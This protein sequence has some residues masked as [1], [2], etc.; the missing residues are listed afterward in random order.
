M[1]IK[2]FTT[3]MEDEMYNK[4]EHIA[5]FEGRSVNS[6]LL[7]LVRQSIEQHEAKYGEIDGTVKPAQNVKL[8]RMDYSEDGSEP[9]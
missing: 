8:G 6:Q 1:A 2:A 7:V 5:D 4:L 3:R 9:T